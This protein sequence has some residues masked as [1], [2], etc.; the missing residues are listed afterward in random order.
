MTPTTSASV[1]QR[2][3]EEMQ[4]EGRRR[5]DR[6][7]D[8]APG[9][10]AMTRDR[11]RP[12]ALARQVLLPSLIGG[13]GIACLLLLA[14]GGV[15][16]AKATNLLDGGGAELTQRVSSDLEGTPTS[17]DVRQARRPPGEGRR[18]L[19]AHPY[20]ELYKIAERRFGVSWFLVASVHYQETGFGKAPARL[21]QRATW[22]RDRH[23]AR[24]I[25]RPE[26]YRHR[27]AGQP[28]VRD[29]FDV[30]MAIAAEL[31]AAGATDLGRSA[32]RATAARYEG[33][34]G[35]KLSSAMVIERA[36]AWKLLGTLP[37]P[38]RGELAK[39]VSGVIGG[40]G[41][42]G[43]P[44]PG[45]LHN[46]VDFLAPHRTPIHAADAGTVALLESPAESGGYGIFVCLQHRPHLATCYA[47]LAALAST[48]RLG[49]KIRRGQVVGL[50]G[51]TG[52]SIAPHLHFEV[53]R[54]AAD[55]QAC[56]ID[57]LALLDGE[58]PQ[59]TVPEMVASPRR[60]SATVLGPVSVEPAPAALRRP[61][62]NGP[63]ATTPV[64]PVEGPSLRGH[65]TPGA[66]AM[67]PEPGAAATP[68]AHT[69]ATGGTA[70]VPSTPQPQPLAPPA[71]PAAAPPVA[72]AS[73]VAAPPP[74]AAVPA[75]V[76]TDAG[77]AR[78]PG[79]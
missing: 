29:D 45:H 67:S 20:V 10:G 34:A 25:A 35:G 7:E 78:P 64:V 36:R 68:A 70:P 28:S 47:H 44:R 74:P 27:R 54:G 14:V 77:G 15:R 66:A 55:C 53:R 48:V 12:A 56:A 50:V 75:P 17:A 9:G 58:V 39:P 51:S 3:P 8:A 1:P 43:C 62:P 52:S 31:A 30:V 59:A 19:A 42:F 2:P 33:D 79:P 40:C 4:A 22:R 23:A 11:V 6:V 57:P 18:L 65:P 61:G 26:R 38:G 60:D 69:P 71:P 37:L 13:A 32:E 49:G 63:S 5:R 72:P 24:G 41:Y 73:A 16:W 76:S 46:G 21:A